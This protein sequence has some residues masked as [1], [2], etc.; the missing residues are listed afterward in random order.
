MAESDIGTVRMPAQHPLQHAPLLAPTWLVGKPTRTAG[1]RKH[2]EER[3]RRGSNLLLCKPS[4]PSLLAG[5]SC[6]KRVRL[7]ILPGQAA[8]TR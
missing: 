8:V 6:I 1:V 7:T 3:K 2:A 4:Q 5:V